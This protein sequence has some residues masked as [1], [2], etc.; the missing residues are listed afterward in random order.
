MCYF[1]LKHKLI[2]SR[3]ESVALPSELPYYDKDIVFT[4]YILFRDKKFTLKMEISML[5]IPLL[6]FVKFV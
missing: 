4:R 2:G 6:K 1:F 3:V 5:V